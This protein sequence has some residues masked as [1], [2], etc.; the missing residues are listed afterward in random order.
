VYPT[1]EVLVNENLQ[2]GLAHVLWLGGGTDAGKSTI[3]RIIA[4]RYGLQIYDYDQRDIPQTNRLAETIT[5]YRD[6]LEAS[7]EERWIHPEPE[8]LLYEAIQSFKDRFPLVVEELLAMPKE[9]VILAEGFGLAPELIFPL[10]S[11]KRQAIWLVPSETFKW[12]SMNRRRKFTWM[13]D[14]ERA[15]YNLFTRDMLLSEWVV[16]QAGLRGLKVE[17]VDGSCSVEEMAD[18]VD[19][20]FKVYLQARNETSTLK[21]DRG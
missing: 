15:I 6:F 12:S 20:H 14:P 9:P 3:S 18:V 2:H 7:D 17:V 5:H 16:E 10:L 19:R 11:D 21:F 1:I 4:E 13:S 8:D